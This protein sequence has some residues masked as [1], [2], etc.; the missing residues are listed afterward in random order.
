V[1]VY[2]TD[3]S[4]EYHRVLTGV[5]VGHPNDIKPDGLSDSRKE[6][7]FKSIREYCRVGTEDLVCP[8]PVE[9]QSK[10]AKLD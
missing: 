7:L 10:R 1:K 2:S 9:V 6:Y 4:Y 8:K 5:P 3:E